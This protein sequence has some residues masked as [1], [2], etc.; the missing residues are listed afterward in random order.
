MDTQHLRISPYQLVFTMFP[1]E[2]A[3]T[4][5]QSVRMPQYKKNIWLQMIDI[6]ILKIYNQKEG[7]IPNIQYLNISNNLDSLEIFG[8]ELQIDQIYNYL[9][10]YTIQQKFEDNY[11]IIKLLGK[12]S[13]AKVYK[14]KKIHINLQ[15]QDKQEYTYASKIFNKIK[16][17]QNQE[18]NEMSLWKEIEIMRLMKNK[19]II[20]LFEVF[21]DEKKIYLLLDFLQGR[22]LLNHIY[23][24]DNVYD[25]TLVLKLMHNVLNGLSYIHSH[26]II[27]RDIKPE[28]LILKQKNNIEDII[29]ADFGLADFYNPDGDYLF[30]RC[31][32]I[33]YIAPEMLNNEKYDYKVDV[34]SLGTVFFLLLTGQ[35]AFEGQSSQEIFTRNQK[36]KIDFKLLDQTNISQAAKDL[37]MKMLKQNPIERISIDEAL[38]HPWLQRRKQN[39]YVEPFKI[40]KK[41]TI[42]RGLK[43]IVRCNTPLW[44]NKS[45]KSITDSSDNQDYLTFNVRDQTIQDFVDEELLRQKRGSNNYDLEDDTI[46]EDQMPSYNV[47]KHFPLVKQNSFP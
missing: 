10:L 24:N 30:K 35:Q 2:I 7:Q 22:D 19:H 14:V 5:L 23:K 11:Q 26:N 12:G 37:C 25:E 1:Q 38:I 34:Y 21:E 27:H 16:L 31:G 44:I 46:E 15:S 45:L 41:P 17:R 47:N 4:R 13:F 32:S 40:I 18:E 3:S 28:N 43:D 9:K 29:L 6:L 39:L 42:V 33:G 8:P 36:G 20:K